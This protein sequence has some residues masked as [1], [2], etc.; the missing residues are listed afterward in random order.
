MPNLRIPFLREKFIHIP[1]VVSSYV[2]VF[3]CVALAF[4]V[5]EGEEGVVVEFPE[6]VVDPDL[7]VI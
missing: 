2:R 6:V 1:I 5:T 4:D 7:F 3:I